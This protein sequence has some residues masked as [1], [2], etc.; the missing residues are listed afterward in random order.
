MTSK[1]SRWPAWLDMVQG[2][3]GLFLVLFMWVHMFFVSSILLGK[4]AM[5]S[6]ARFF[7]GEPLFGEPYPILVS[8]FAIFILSLIVVHAVLAVRKIPSSYQQYAKMNQHLLRFRH[9]DSLL[10]YVQVATGFA[11]MFL[12]AVHLYQLIMHPANIGP[13][14]SSDRVW[15]S[16]MWPLYLILLFVVEIHGGV[17]IY[18]LIIKWGWF[19]GDDVKK[20]RKRLQTIKWSITGF[21][22]VLGILTLGAYMKIGADHSD[23][24]GERYQP[25]VEHT[26]TTS[27]V[28]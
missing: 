28:N 18:R 5:H 13:Y 24:A 11:L 14:A 16:R 3:T 21:F 7:E 27:S 10:W 22:L 12:A 1:L 15:S 9:H 26:S 20:S 17:G 4:D 8:F 2:G 25:S 19:L 23:H 6:V